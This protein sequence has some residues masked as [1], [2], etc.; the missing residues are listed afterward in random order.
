MRLLTKSG[1]IL[2]PIA[3]VLGYVMS[4]IFAVLVAMNIPN[5]GLSIVLFTI[6]IYMVMLP[7]TYR[8]QK[9][10]RMTPLM[11]PE[12]TAIREKYKGKNDQATMQRMNEETK[13]VYAKYGVNPA[14][15]CVQLVV[16]M[17]ILFPL[18]RVIMN[19]PAYV[20]QV[21]AVFEELA[22]KLLTTPGA[23]KYLQEIGPSIQATTISKEFTANTIIDTLYKF[24]PDNWTAL[25]Q[26]FPDL[27]DI[28]SSTEKVIGRMNN[29]LGMNIAN[30]PMNYIKEHATVWLVIGAILVPVL[31]ALTQWL[32]V[33]VSMA[34]NT[35]PEGS[36]QMAGTMKMMN[37][38]MPLMSA[39]FCLTL[40]VGMG[41]Y[42][43]M[44]AVVRMVQTILINKRL[45]KQDMEE[46][47]RKNMEKSKKK[48]EKKGGVSGAQIAQNAA[49]NTRKVDDSVSRAKRM[50][51]AVTGLDESA[52][53]KRANVRPGSLAEKANMVSEYN[54]K[55]RK[56]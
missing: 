18:Y 46:I 51:K 39:F 27:G 40:P 2:G 15:S 3:T 23:E 50:Q 13:Q 25:A 45:E 30:T 52:V 11:N 47:L 28:I 35:Q 54:E 41:I 7:L 8:Q 36:D 16:Q 24:R 49:I 32:S 12:L 26:K 1:G 9:F 31:A 42:W 34:G 21:K 29:F 22:S 48:M 6:V 43:I 4:G 55:H 38:I 56:K 14:G 20:S 37:N 17:L 10:S 53:T 33:K 44:S 5:I 19:V